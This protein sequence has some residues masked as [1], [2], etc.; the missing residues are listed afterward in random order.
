MSLYY[1]WVEA[2]N[3]GNFVDDTPDLS[4]VRG[5]GLLLLGAVEDITGTVHTSQLRTLTTGASAG[6]YEFDAADSTAAN[7][8]WDA[9]RKTLAS[10]SELRHATFVVSVQPKG[11]DQAFAQ[12]IATLQ[13]KNRWQQMQSPS[14]SLS[15]MN[16]AQVC[17]IDLV[18]PATRTVPAPENKSYTVSE[19]VAVRRLAGQRLKQKFYQEHIGRPLQRNFT[20]ELNDL[21]EDKAKGNL[22]GKMAVIYLDGN[23]FGSI[24]KSVSNS[25]TEW[26]KFDQ[27][28]KSYRREM[29]EGLLDRMEIDGDWQ[30]S[31]GKYRIETLLWGGDELMWIVPAWKGWE[32]LQYFYQKSKDW[33]F[34]D[35]PLRHSGGLV[36]CHHNAPI[37][38]ITALAR[39]LAELAKANN[40]REHNRFAYEVL[41]SFDHVGRDLQQYRKERSPQPVNSADPVNPQVLILAGESM[42]A[43]DNFITSFAEEMPRKQLHEITNELL[44]RPRKAVD[45]MERQK[46][47]DAMLTRIEKTVIKA[48]IKEDELKSLQASFDSDEAFWLHVN[49]LWDYLA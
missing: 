30:T 14:L 38:R 37:H 44:W 34:N 31:D 46:K 3:L 47:R 23:Q 7:A 19:S 15:S 27:T 6:L 40:G 45:V 5:G 12:D 48:G 32:T 21:T 13:A 4:T 1:L 26:L 22:D 11:N 41:E 35:P 20:H 43:L 10:D 25:G 17:D 9:V 49:A 33:H 39:S 29:L 16:A 24:K 2:V 28:V 8:V 42:P 18:R 36:F